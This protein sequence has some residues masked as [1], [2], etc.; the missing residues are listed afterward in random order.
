VNGGR[1]NPVLLYIDLYILL[2]VPAERGWSSQ[3]ASIIYICICMCLSCIYI[4]FI[5]LHWLT[6]QQKEDEAL[7]LHDQAHDVQD[8]GRGGFGVD[9]DV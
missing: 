7:G 6:Y 4:T 9:M 8:D 5:Y 2:D 1:L 3:P